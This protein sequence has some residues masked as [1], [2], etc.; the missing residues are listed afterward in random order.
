M[1][2]NRRKFVKMAGIGSVGIIAGGW[3]S[4]NTNQN[5]IK[6]LGPVDGDMLTAYDGV[7]KDGCLVTKVKIS[8]PAG[9]SVR[10]NG[11]ITRYNG[12][13]FIAEAILKDYSND[14]EISETHS[15]FKETI[16]VFWLKNIAGKYR[17]SLDDNIL[18][19]KDINSKADV[20]TSIFDNPYLGFLKQVHDTYDTKIHMNIY[21]QTEGFNLSQMT[22]K[23]KHEWKENAGWLKL[24]FHAL[25]NDPDRPYIN[26]GYDEVKRD[27]EKVKEQIRRF[28]GEEVMGPVTT[29]HWGAATVYG[30][31]ALSDSGYKALAGYFVVEKGEEPVSYYLDED[32]KLNLSKRIAWK[33]NKEGIIFSRIN[34]VINSHKQDEIVPYL[35]EIKKD[36]HR[37]AYMEVMIHEQ[38][39]HPDYIDYQPDYREKVMTT[40]KWVV[41]NGYKPAFLSE[42]LFG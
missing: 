10:V 23:Y 38:Y 12:E 42:V 6:I 21:Y 24:S 7:V 40:I 1:K 31:R 32:Q 26:A 33:D 19:L 14:L 4:G 28:A 8:A 39:F 34:I 2:T 16:K 17:F 27:C 15:G 3:V 11:K 22:D 35:N 9:S 30:C 29:L 18:F 20:Y 13:F 25:Q 36:P 41:D 37:S 5:M